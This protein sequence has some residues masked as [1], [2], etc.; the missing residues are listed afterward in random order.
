[1]F[2]AKRAI[3]GRFFKEKKWTTVDSAYK[4][5][6]KTLKEKVDWYLDAEETVY[7]GLAD[8]VLGSRRFKDIDKLKGIK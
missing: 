8:G 7:Y 6:E 1:M 4:F 3:R 2:F 5:F